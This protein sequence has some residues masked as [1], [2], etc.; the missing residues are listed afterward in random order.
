MPATAYSEPAAFTRPALA[1]IPAS[2][3]LA[4]YAKADL[5][6]AALAGKSGAPPAFEAFA[7]PDAVTFYST[8]ELARGPA[9]IRRWLGAD[10]AAWS[11]RPV[12]AGGT[13]DLGFT[14]GESVITP[15]GESPSYGKYLTLWRRLPGGAIRYIADGGNARPAPSQ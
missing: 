8:G 10:D 3:P 12:A 2:G 4:D 15:K 11:W 6:F 14:V 7:A 13:A 1:P 9:G 5:Q